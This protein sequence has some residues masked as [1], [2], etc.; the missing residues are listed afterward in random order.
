MHKGLLAATLST[1]GLCS[2]FPIA[3]KL[4]TTIFESTEPNDLATGSKHTR[5]SFYKNWHYSPPRQASRPWGTNLISSVF[6]WR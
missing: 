5:F 4:Q 1:S 3:D 2:F 6:T